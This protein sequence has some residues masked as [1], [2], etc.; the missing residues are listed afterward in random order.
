MKRGFEFALKHLLFDILY[1]SLLIRRSIALSVVL[2]F[3][4]PIAFSNVSQSSIHSALLIS[5]EQIKGSTTPKSG[6][7]RSW[8]ENTIEQKRVLLGNEALLEP[9][10]NRQSSPFSASHGNSIPTNTDLVSLLEEVFQDDVTE[11]DLESAINYLIE[12]QFGLSR[13]SILSALK[14]VLTAYTKAIPKSQNIELS[15][16]YDRIPYILL[17]SILPKAKSFGGNGSSWIRDLSQLSIEVAMES[18]QAE[19]TVNN[20]SS[21]YSEEVF[22]L[23]KDPQAFFNDR[24]SM[25]PAGAPT[26]F[27][28]PAV[29]VEDAENL[30]LALDIR[31]GL[32]DIDPQRSVEN[33]NMEYGGLSGFDPAKT[34]VFQELSIGLTQGFLNVKGQANELSSKD[35]DDLS[36]GSTSPS[37]DNQ[38]NIEPSVVSSVINGILDQI[39]LASI[40][41]DGEPGTNGVSVFAYDILKATANGF[42]L[43]SSI[44]ASSSD[45]YL[46]DGLHTES[47]ENLSQS[48][49]QSAILHSF[50]N[51]ETN[52]V[53]WTVDLLNAGRISESIAHGA[54]MGSQLAMVQPKS[55]DYGNNYEVFTNSRREIAK[56]VSKGAANG[57]VNASAW[58]NSISSANPDEVP[59]ITTA[60]IEEVSRGTALGAMIGNTGLAVYYPTD[61]LVPI[62]N[63]SAQGASYGTTSSSN[64]SNV[65]KEGTETID[66]SMT[67]E[68]ALGSAMGAAFEPTALMQLRPDLR[69]RDAQTISHLEAAAFGSTYGAILGI[70]ANPTPPVPNDKL[71]TA[72]DDR[73][74]EL[75]QSA[76]QGS[77]EGSLSGSQLALGIE[78]TSED[79]LQSKSAILKAINTSNAKA[80][81]NSNQSSSLNSLR[82]NSRDMLLLM[83]KFGINP[84]FT[85]P[86]KIYKRPVVVQIDEPPVDDDLEDAFKDASPL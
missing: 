42:L 32:T 24:N 11:Q 51:P 2:S 76:K 41:A 1:M 6:Q 30:L 28:E 37:S 84:R 34:M 79:S 25:S 29:I 70:Q 60:E 12:N 66:V 33:A 56:S 22:L 5:L 13:E 26:D 40:P 85:N 14:S 38:G 23:L 78:D 17:K 58:L 82:T 39:H 8:S 63:F 69:S 49:S 35:F 55:M 46:E 54:A 77:I 67:R 68:S 75:K 73:L 44:A 27:T 48:L 81:A 50:T 31:P 4:V 61:Q 16:S 18:G 10:D 86:A 83:K 80:A 15:E 52:T 65:I 72:Q 43:A 62:I 36:N 64:L 20:L 47:A 59:I 21:S 57:S 7:R 53:S 45:R 71:G 9:Q 19:Q 3:C 74:V